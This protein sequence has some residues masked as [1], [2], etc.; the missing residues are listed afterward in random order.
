[1]EEEQIKYFVADLNYWLNFFGEIGK[2]VIRHPY[3]RNIFV[4]TFEQKDKIKFVNQVGTLELCFPAI[5][6]LVYD[7]AVEK[8][9][10]CNFV[11]DDYT[12]DMKIVKELL[13]KIYESISRKEITPEELIEQQKDFAKIVDEFKKQN[14]DLLR[15]FIQI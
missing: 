2:Y 6:K 1:M 14:K 3:S 12:K 11:S 13:D 15:N 9:T 8:N 4:K 7:L 5:K 10:S